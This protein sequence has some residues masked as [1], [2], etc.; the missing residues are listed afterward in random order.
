MQASLTVALTDLCIDFTLADK[1]SQHSFVLAAI[2][3]RA[4]VA[5]T[6]SSLETCAKQAS[7]AQ[8]V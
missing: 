3:D 1:V 8:Y 6:Y 5:Y 4:G 2:T 7:K